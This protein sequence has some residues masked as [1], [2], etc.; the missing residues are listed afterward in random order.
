MNMKLKNIDFE[1][2]ETQKKVARDSERLN[3]LQAIEKVSTRLSSEFFVPMNVH[4]S[5]YVFPYLS[6]AEDLD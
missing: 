5:I 2:K 6:Q 3:R 4:Y 1:R